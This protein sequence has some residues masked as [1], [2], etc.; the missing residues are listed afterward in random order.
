MAATSGV[1]DTSDIL[2]ARLVV[3]MSDKIHLLEDNKISLSKMLSRLPK[4][5]AKATTVRWMTDEIVPK[6]TTLAEALD[7]S[8]TG[9]DVASGTGAYF[10]ANDI[11]KIAQT[12]ET[13]LVSSVSTDTLTVTRSWGATAAAAADTG[14]VLL[15]LGAAFSEGAHL[16]VSDSDDSILTNRMTEVENTNYTQ[17][18]RDAVGLTRTQQQVAT[19]GGKVREGDRKKKAIEHVQ[20]IN[21]ALYHGEKAAS[22]T[23]RTLGGLN[24]FVPSANTFSTATLTEAQF[25]TDLKTAF[26]YG[27]ES[28]VLFCSRAIAG[29]IS[30]WASVVQRVSPGESKFGVA[31]TKYTSP[32]GEVAIVTDHALEGTVYDKYAF[33]VDIKDVRLRPL[34]DTALLVDRQSPDLD[35]VVDE[36]LTET[37]FEMGTPRNHSKWNAVTS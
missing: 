32:H 17:I 13:C 16:R 34:Q 28:K 20:K 25:N 10:K 24:E 12:G 6:S 36:Y 35:G 30:E 7:D 23:R 4:S 1:T 29:I 21:L 19:Y 9:I 15:N 22:G 2:A 33:L 26:R 8:E 3:D 5:P 11:V 37:S 27:S 31:I 18:F 14:G